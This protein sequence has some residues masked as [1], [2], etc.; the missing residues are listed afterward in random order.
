M[1]SLRGD[2]RTLACSKAVALGRSSAAPATSLAMGLGADGLP[3]DL[4]M[5]G[6]RFDDATVLTLAAARGRTSSRGWRA[7][8]KNCLRN[9]LLSY[10][11]SG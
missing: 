10:E 11:R 2:W 6:R 5:M 7:R 8:K 3:V 4:Q 1:G 9:R